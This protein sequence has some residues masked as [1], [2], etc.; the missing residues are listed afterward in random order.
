VIFCSSSFGQ[1]HDSLAHYLKIA[2]E[3]NPALRAAFYVYEAA[4]EKIPQAGAFQDPQLDIG[5]FLEPMEI[6]TGL[7]VGQF[8]IMQ[9]F[10]WFGTRKAARTEAEHMAKMAF[11]QFREARD[12]LFFD[13]YTQW[14]KLCRLQQQL[15]NNRESKEFLLQL[16]E[17]ALKKFSSPNNNSTSGSMSVKPDASSG[18]GNKQGMSSG[19]NSMKGMTM[20]N[21]AATQS[22]QGSMV[23]PSQGNMAQ[24]GSSSSSMVDLL[25]I[26]LEVAE[27]DNNIES[28]LS[29]IDAEKVGFNVL[30]NRSFGSEIIIPDSLEQIPFLLDLENS[31][32]TIRAQNPMLGMITEE[33]STF[34]AKTEMDKKMSYP[35]FGI[36]LQ[37]MLINKKPVPETDHNNN[38]SSMNGKDMFMPM[39]SISIPF[40]RKKYNA[41][42]RENELLQK[43]SHEKYIN[44]LN[45]FEAE[46]HSTKN[47][48][49]N[50][51]KK[52]TLY[53]KQSELVRTTLNLMLQEFA[54]GKGDLSN[55]IQVQRQLLD[56]LLKKGEAIVDYNIMVANVQK[57]ISI[58]GK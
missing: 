49:E 56:Y 13:V 15:N 14:F 29:Q 37:Y 55:V 57:L 5:L 40:F 3:N 52:I 54:S 19:G 17:L 16:E 4:L 50:A 43:A 20:G 36:G 26:R 11:E 24:M 58:K 39:V 12:Q 27:L 33:E 42:Q 44:T 51:A 47:Q 10:P 34:K 18:A 2:G 1:I 23:I 32:Q 53:H 28:I 9:M 48:L 45:M 25:N 41:Q 22:V 46:L 30:L 38:M 6:V 7:Q 31:M 8:Q 35:M 21:T